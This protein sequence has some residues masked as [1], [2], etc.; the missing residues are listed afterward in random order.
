MTKKNNFIAI[1]PARAGSKEIK[2][3]NLIKINGH[4]LVS[5]SIIAAKKSKFI[6][7]VFV[8]TDGN[9]IAKI[10]RKYGAKV[11]SRPKHLSNDTAQIESAILHAIKYIEKNLKKKVENIIMLQ[12]TSALRK[13]DDL[14]NSIKKFIK[15]KADSLFSC[16][17]LHSYIWENKNSKIVPLNYNYIRRK[18]RQAMT[19]S[20]IENGSIY[21][22]KKKIYKKKRCRLGGKISK[23]VMENYS[24]FQVDTK[25]DLKFIS[26]L[27]KSKIKKKYK[28][29]VPKK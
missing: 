6:R 25:E 15:D 5:Y 16:V 21:I 2:K 23:Y 20:L 17:D 10:S 14:D 19:Q 27:L 11:I 1:I 22:T 12:P 4:P 24:V 28:I 13:V 18:N 8:T 29:I 26:T 3:K 9:D 7:E